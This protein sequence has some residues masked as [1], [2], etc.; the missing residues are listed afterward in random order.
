MGGVNG[1]MCMERCDGERG[2][3]GRGASGRGVHA[4]GIE[5]GA[6]SASRL[7]AR[8]CDGGA[9]GSTT[10]LLVVLGWEWRHHYRQY[11]RVR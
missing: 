6:R 9:G 8:T 10:L 3:D 7:F 4:R 11:H 5:R 1:E 2:V